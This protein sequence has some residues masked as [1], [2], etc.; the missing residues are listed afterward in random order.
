MAEINGKY[1]YNL[2]TGE[3]IGIRKS[4]VT[5]EDGLT[6]KE[7]TRGIFNSDSEDS[8]GGWVNF[9]MLGNNTTSNIQY[10]S[11]E[12]LSFTQIV[13]LFIQGNLTKEELLVG[14][15][16]KNIGNINIQD[17]G[18]NINATFAM[19]GKTYTLKCATE[20]AASQTD[21]KVVDDTS[22][23]ITASGQ[24]T[25]V[26]ENFQG[27]IRGS[28]QGER[29]DLT[30]TDDYQPYNEPGC[31]LNISNTLGPAGLGLVGENGGITGTYIRNYFGVT[32]MD[33]LTDEQI[34]FINDNPQ[35]F[36]VTNFSK[37]GFA[38][39]ATITKYVIDTFK[40]TEYWLSPEEI[41]SGRIQSFKNQIE[42]KSTKGYF[43]V[44]H[45]MQLDG[46]NVSWNDDTVKYILD[47]LQ[48]PP[49]FGDNEKKQQVMDLFGLKSN[50]D[51]GTVKHKLEMFFKAH[52]S[53]DG[54]SMHIE[55]YYLATKSGESYETIVK[56]YD[57]FLSKIDA[58]AAAEAKRY[59][60]A[61]NDIIDF[62]QGKAT[63]NDIK[64]KG[65]T[66]VGGQ[67]INVSNSDVDVSSN[68]Y[69]YDVNP[70]G[71]GSE[72]V[73]LSNNYPELDY[74]AVERA[75]A[76]KIPENNCT[77]TDVRRVKEEQM[78]KLLS[79]IKSSSADVYLKGVPTLQNS[80]ICQVEVD[81]DGNIIF[82]DGFK[83]SIKY[84]LTYNQQ[85]SQSGFMKLM[86]IP[87]NSV[88]SYLND[89]SIDKLVSDFL[90][91]FGSADGKTLTLE[92]YYDAIV[93]NQ[94]GHFSYNGN[95]FYDL[96]RIEANAEFGRVVQNL[97]E[98]FPDESQTSWS[99]W[100]S[101]MEDYASYGKTTTFD[102]NANWLDNFSETLGGWERVLAFAAGITQKDSNKTKEEKLVKFVKSMGG[103]VETG[104]LNQSIIFSM[105][106]MLRYLVGNNPEQVNYFATMD[107]IEAAELEFAEKVRDYMKNYSSAETDSSIKVEKLENDKQTKVDNKF[108]NEI[109]N[110]IYDL[111][112]PLYNKYYARSGPGGP[113]IY[114]SEGGSILNNN[115][116]SNKHG[117]EPLK[118]KNES[119]RQAFWEQ[120]KAFVPQ[121]MEK[122]GDVIT[123]FYFDGEVFRFKIAGMGNCGAMTAGGTTWRNPECADYVNNRFEDT[124]DHPVFFTTDINVYETKIP[125]K[126]PADENGNAMIPTKWS[127]IYT[128]KEGWVYCYDSIT[129]KY[130]G[131]DCGLGDWLL[132]GADDIIMDDHY[133]HA[134]PAEEY[135]L[136]LPLLFGYNKTNLS[137]VY[138]KDGKFY[139]R[140]DA[141]ISG[142]VTLLE[143]DLVNPVTM[144]EISYPAGSNTQFANNDK[145]RNNVGL[146]DSINS[147]AYEPKIIASPDE[148]R[149]EAKSNF[150]LLQN[151]DV[152]VVK[153]GDMYYTQSNGKRYNY[154]WDPFNHKWLAY[155]PSQIVNGVAKDQNNP[156]LVRIQMIVAALAQ[157]LSFTANPKVCKDK[158]GNVYEFNEVSCAFEKQA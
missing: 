74:N 141:R 100:I 11:V 67:N 117:T 150:N 10:G 147:D 121:I 3:T 127:G 120:L 87:E 111:V 34:K 134:I 105:S 93:N 16:A 110:W 104:I 135:D 44:V 98:A 23:K 58:S 63:L 80:P 130:V 6:G 152:A 139:M 17:D 36:H 86:G 158:D 68:N 133:G 20:A 49:P 21:D 76:T 50:D 54:K 123:E 79:A 30:I 101:Q 35:I 140:S 145:T 53:S 148:Y 25:R 109:Q 83:K 94:D 55:D 153:S 129:Q 90:Q 45:Q 132:M 125:S 32:D 89:S 29:I 14:L 97:K 8:N 1:M 47:Y 99:Y 102:L 9:Y 39:D 84:Y 143:I 28:G 78:N 82:G 136:V 155:E 31:L 128:T 24:G 137:G 75:P 71:Y 96:D 48:S 108:M 2:S 64:S 59:G 70:G 19:D 81:Q 7:H 56:Q 69:T 46:N 154:L 144:Q 124:T 103:T 157:G 156:I 12:D 62:I 151:K 33:N 41:Y 52:G 26:Y 142:K 119:D 5:E 73:L 118:W 106:E 37:G 107:N 112:S 61:E 116:D 95:T 77:E 149:Q 114:F 85:F 115:V 72:T 131:I 146:T 51:E 43:G 18:D 65:A 88:S 38:H 4:K 13:E 22:N 113:Y 42:T 91:R 126:A 92:Q 138:E 57:D 15:K 60:R 27:P 66:I 40:D 122:Y